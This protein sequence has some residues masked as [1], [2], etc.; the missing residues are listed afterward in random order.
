M[1]KEV[2][3]QGT[4]HIQGFGILKGRGKRL[5]ALKKLLPR[6]KLIAAD[7]TNFSAAKYC[8]KGAQSHEE[9]DKLGV[10][11]P[12]FG[13]AADFMEYGELPISNYEAG[14]KATKK[15]YEDAWNLAKKGDIENIP[16]ELLIRHYHSFKRIQQDYPTKPSDL[17]AVCGL[18][19]YGPPGSGKSLYARK[20]YGESLYDK[21]INKWWDGYRFEKNIL[22]DDFDLDHKCLGHHLKRW[23]DRYSFPAE[24]KGTT[25]QIRPEKIIITSNYRIGEIFD[26]PT[27]VRAL[28]RRFTVLPMLDEYVP[29]AI[30]ES[31]DDTPIIDVVDSPPHYVRSPDP[32]PKIRLKTSEPAYRAHMQTFFQAINDKEGVNINRILSFDSSSS[33]SSEEI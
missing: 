14:G 30:E 7:A 5:T 10:D 17:P 2:G 29:E 3:E 12:N 21:N 32:T 19:I 15:K 4:P 24:M 13:L 28:E 33:E 27:L 11:G 8:M 6:A 23:A 9:W 16:P 20:Q 25:I 31:S 18:W 22:I 1:G 26:D